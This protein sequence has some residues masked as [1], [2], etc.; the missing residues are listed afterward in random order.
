MNVESFEADRIMYMVVCITKSALHGKLSIRTIKTLFTKYNDADEG[1]IPFHT[2][3][4]NYNLVICPKEM[5]RSPYY[6]MIQMDVCS[7]HQSLKTA[8]P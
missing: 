4:N 8:A 2:A 7:P 1:V 5:R 6:H 3:K